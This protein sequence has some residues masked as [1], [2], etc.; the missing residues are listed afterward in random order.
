MPKQLFEVFWKT[1]KAGKIFR[2]IIKN[3]KKDGTHYWVDAVISPVIDEN[4]NVLKYI[5]IRYLIENEEIAKNLFINK[6]K[7]LNINLNAS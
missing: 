6:C 4:G 1:I 7:E 2:G 5:G 3:K